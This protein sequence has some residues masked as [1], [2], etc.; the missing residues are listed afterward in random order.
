MIDK[1]ILF[2]LKN[3]NLIKSLLILATIT[4][5]IVTMLPPSKLGHSKLFMYDKLGHFL[6]FF[7]W[8]LLFGLFMFNKKRT[9][10][11]FLL[12]FLSG[13]FFGIG[14]EILQELLPFGRTMDI[15][16]AGLDILGSFIAIGIL[17]FVK[18]RY[19]SQEMEDQLKKI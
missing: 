13:S 15:R 9:E 4:T 11:K 3:R 18:K 6:I 1:A 12:I 14:I 19:L 17:F 7:A 16:D 5:L 10:T 2:C 8:T